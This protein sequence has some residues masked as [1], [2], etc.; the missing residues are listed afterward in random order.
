[1]RLTTPLTPPPINFFL[2]STHTTF[3]SWKGTSKAEVSFINKSLLTLGRVILALASGSPHIPYRESKLTRLLSEALGGVCKTTFVCCASPAAVNLAE[4][5][6]T[7][8][9]ARRAGQAL[10]IASLPKNQQDEV[11]R[12][13]EIHPRAFFF[14]VRKFFHLALHLPPPFHYYY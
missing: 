4:T 10:N 9:Y 3:C 11:R 5:A 7:L 8:R 12:G 14:F 13:G 2:H 1:M 6:S